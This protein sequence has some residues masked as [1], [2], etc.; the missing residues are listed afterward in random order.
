MPRIRPLIALCA[1][2]LLAG[3][4]TAGS[5]ST[6]ISAAAPSSGRASSVL[7]VIISSELATGPNRFLFSFLDA[8]SNA[9][10]GAPD[11]TASVA[12]TGPGGQAVAQADG[13]FIWAIEN[14]SG[15]YVSTVDFPASG[16]WVA[17]FT[18]AGGSQ[19]AEQVDFQFQVLDKKHVIVPGDK[20]P[21]VDTPTLASVGGDVAKLSTDTHPD[22]A[23]YETSV[24]A[25][26]AA[27]KPFVLVFATPKFCQTQ[28]CGPTLDKVKPIAAAHPDVTFINVEPYQLKDDQGQL[29]PVLDANGQLQ[30]VPATDAYGLL[31]EPYVFVVGGDGIV[32]ASFEL[33]FT[34]AEIDQALAGLK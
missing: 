31:S 6:S 2:V 20:A 13:T 19:A 27:H 5:S 7:P 34:A 21:S 10:V 23:F 15:I 11:R 18:T 30:T 32:K 14:V 16:D 9:P 24:A 17:H 22:K 33:I 8:T 3:C 1:V 28:T 12:F 25:A 29:Q 26:L 4:S